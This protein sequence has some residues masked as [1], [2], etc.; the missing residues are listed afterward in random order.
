MDMKKCAAIPLSMHVKTYV[1]TILVRCS[2]R[3]F[4]I[5]KKKKKKNKKKKK[6]KRKH[7]RPKDVW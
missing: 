5:E 1:S 6:K 4:V 7:E 3:I 2:I